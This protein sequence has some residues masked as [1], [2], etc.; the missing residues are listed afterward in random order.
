MDKTM[1][2]NIKVSIIT[3]S[4]NQGEYIEETILSVLNQD[5]K[6]IEY[7][8]IDGG[9]TDNTMNIV[10]KYRDKIDIVIHEKDRGQSDA[11]NKGFRLATGEIVGWINSD[12][13][14]Y[15]D[16]V[17]AIVNLYRNNKKGVVF[18]CS[19]LDLIDEK[20]NFIKLV[21]K[22]I[23]DR[24]HLLYNNYDVIQQGSFYKTDTVRQ[25]NYLDESIHYCMDLELWMRL[26]EYGGIYALDQKAYSGFRIWEE[27]KTTTGQ[28][29]FFRDIKI[30]LIKYGAQV[31]SKTIIKLNW[32]ILKAKVKRFLNYKK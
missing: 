10:E 21:E 13:V 3:P 7:I 32:Y 27:T 14:L 28:E 29:R 23:P 15:P 17:S 4:F 6:N 18:Y 24:D 12:D 22:Y 11:I 16:C 9:S 1:S 30:V 25:I 26:L 8:L 20:G 19:K 2:N 31:S 5:Y